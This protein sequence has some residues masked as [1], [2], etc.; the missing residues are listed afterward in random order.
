MANSTRLPTPG[1]DDN[2]WGDILNDFLQVSHNS[3]GT[4]KSSA[5]TAAGGGTV[6]SPTS[7]VASY[8]TAN[9]STGGGGQVIG[10]NNTINFDTQNVLLGSN[11]TV[12]GTTIS[13]L[14]NGTYLF[15]MS[16]IIQDYTTESGGSFPGDTYGFTVGMQEK[17]Q[18]AHPWAQVQPYP[19]AE[20]N[21]VLENGGGWTQ[22]QTVTLSHMITVTKAP[23]DFNVLLNNTTAASAWIANQ[24]INVVQLD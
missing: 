17:Q 6:A 23:V 2:S 21:T 16:A 3:D 11:I 4:L 22:A 1:S 19:L 9:F 5:L 13:V 24:T 10:S 14:A 20:H 15:S 12:S 8:Y 7:N 18:G